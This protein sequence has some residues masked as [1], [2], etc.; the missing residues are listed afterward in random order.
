MRGRV[1]ILAGG[2]NS[3]GKKVSLKTG[4]EQLSVPQG[5]RHEWEEA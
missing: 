3:E 2:K 1:R 5:G 4:K